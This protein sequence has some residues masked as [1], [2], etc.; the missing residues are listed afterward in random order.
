[1]RVCTT[2][3]MR[4]LDSLS[5]E[6]YGIPGQKLMETA[7]RWV[8]I[9]ARN[10]LK[11]IDGETV[12]LLAGRGNNGGDGF[13]AARYLFNLGFDVEIILAAE[14]DTFKG[15]ALINFERIKELKIPYRR[16]A[17]KIPETD[18]VLDAL[19]GTGISGAP[20]G[21]IADAIARINDARRKGA[22]VLAIDIPSGINGND[23]SA[24][25]DAVDADSTVTFGFAK[26]GNLIHPGKALA[27]RLFI[28][29][30]G[31]D[32]HAK[33]E[34]AI[35]HEFATIQEIAA[36]LP[37]RPPDGHKGTFGKGLIVAGSAGMTGAAVMSGLAVLRAGAGLC[38]AAIPRSLVDI[39]DLAATEVVVL[40]MPEV[41]KKRCH[42]L[43]ALGELHKHV[44]NV[45][46]VAVGPGLGAH[47]ETIE[48][49]RRFLTKI[50]TP[51]VI[52]ADGLNALGGTLDEE[53]PR[54]TAP[55]VMTPHP[56]E[57]SRL[58]DIPIVKVQESRI[59]NALEWAKLLF[60]TLVVKGNPTIVACDEHS[61]WF[62]PTGN[63]GMA[64]AGSGDVL[65]GLIAGFMAQG[66]S[67]WDAARAGVYVHGLAGDIAADNYT[68]R[69]MVAMDILDCVPD[70]FLMLENLPK[71]SKIY[72]EDFDLEYRVTDTGV[73]MS[74]LEPGK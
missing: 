33:A 49:V 35:T 42:T 24:A 13:V 4:K 45:D 14:P 22:L 63:D 36:L 74:L 27:G 25:G 50:Q 44:K 67:P 8:S 43:R 41:K 12:C 60:T 40:S 20:R 57:L 58:L 32:A 7:G 26:I 68:G 23:G 48:M 53:I 2:E 11:D 38:Y 70:S 47:H 61:T 34:V 17:N 30:I 39:V 1:M 56:G 29:D 59:E 6:K 62:N 73:G 9:V 19:L 31:L 16:F 55:S 3:Q 28:A 21:E 64:T 69:A 54:I 65:T 72:D 15:D 5:I 46:T 52:D 66:L 18:I 10:M 37:S 51:V 71:G